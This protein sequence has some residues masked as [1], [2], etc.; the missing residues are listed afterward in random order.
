MRRDLEEL[1][2][3]PAP[4]RAESRP[5]RPHVVGP[6]PDQPLDLVGTGIGGEIEVG[7]RR[8]GRREERV[9]HGTPDEIQTA[10]GLAETARPAQPSHPEEGGIAR[11][12][13]WMAP[14][15]GSAASSV[16]LCRR[17]GPRSACAFSRWQRDFSSPERQ[18]WPRCRSR[19]PPG[20]CRAPPRPRPS[21]H[22]A[23]KRR[24]SP[25]P[26][27]GSRSPQGWGRPPATSATSTSK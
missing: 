3:P 25:R 24:G 27:P 6:A 17:A 4:D 20:V 11:A 23:P 1:A 19:R 16:A 13:T 18:P 22:W 12:R 26:R 2:A 21:S 7:V 15:H 10:T 9:A 5:L 8:S 14:D